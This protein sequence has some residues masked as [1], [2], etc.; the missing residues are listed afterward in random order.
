MKPK[1][2][3]KNS[4]QPARGILSKMPP[5][6]LHLLLGEI[7]SLMLLS[8]VH[9]MFQLRDIADII[10]P[11][12]NLNQFRMY[13]NGKKEPVALVTWGRF[14]RDVEKQYL[15]GKMMLS[16]QELSSG[17]MIYITDF[18]APYGHV[19]QVAR[20]LKTNIFPN[21]SGKA[22]RFTQQ[23][24]HTGRVWTFHGVN[25]QKPLN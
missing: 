13:R 20:D 5:Q 9:R 7:A 11:A 2:Q 10:L 22:I 15:A 21:A 19:R 4:A 3:H 12:I 17:D 16:E 1:L 8:R 24:K 23:G 14:S 6:R 25:Y 18:I